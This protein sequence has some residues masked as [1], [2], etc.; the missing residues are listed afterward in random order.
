MVDNREKQINKSASSKLAIK[1]QEERVLNIAKYYSMYSWT[2]RGYKK[3]A[4]SI[5][6]LIEGHRGE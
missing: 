4:D 5:Q 1:L 2:Y 6:N 3:Q